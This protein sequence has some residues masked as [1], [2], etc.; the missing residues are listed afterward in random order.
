MYERIFELFYQFAMWKINDVSVSKFLASA[1][2]IAM[3]AFSRLLSSYI[4]KFFSV[5][6]ALIMYFL[7]D[8][9]LLFR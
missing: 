4:L 5:I 2:L 6:I 9:L 8:V 1:L 7:P 3:V